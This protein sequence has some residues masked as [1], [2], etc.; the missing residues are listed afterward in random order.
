[1]KKFVLAALGLLVSVSANPSLA[2]TF[3]SGDVSLTGIGAQF[4]SVFDQINITGGSGTFLDSGQSGVN[5]ATG[6]FL[7]GVN[8]NP[9]FNTVS[10]D[11][12]EAFSLNGNPAQDFVIHYVWFSNFATDFLTLSITTGVLNFGNYTATLEISPTSLQSGVGPSVPFELTADI[13]PTP[14]PIAGAGLPG[15][16]LAGGGLVGWWRRRRRAEVAA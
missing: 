10:G 6:S 16:I 5:I 7:V 3:T 4:P 8:C 1:M 13:V 14:G 11:I 15:L 2:G 12:N 9:C